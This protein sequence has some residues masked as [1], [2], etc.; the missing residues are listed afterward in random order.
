M[1]VPTAAVV[2]AT[3]MMI[4]VMVWNPLPKRWS[5]SLESNDGLNKA[6]D[7]CNDDNDAEDD[8]VGALTAR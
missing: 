5:L 1:F 8:D 2:V 4:V 6:C 7:K 3:M